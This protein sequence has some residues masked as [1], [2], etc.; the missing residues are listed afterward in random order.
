[1]TTYFAYC[2]LLAFI[3]II[4]GVYFAAKRYP[5]Y[6]HK[7]QFC[8][9]LG[10]SGSP[11]EKFSP[12]IN[13]YPLAVL[14]CFF[15]ISVIQLNTESTLMIVIGALIILHGIGTWVTGYF[16]MDADAY[17][18]VPTL[19]CQIHSLAGMVMLLALLAAPILVLFVPDNTYINATFKTFSLISVIITIFF[20]LVLAKAYK[21][22]GNVGLYQRLG[23]GCQLIWLS[24]LSLM[25]VS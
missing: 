22:K 17:T 7:K 5:R 10:A 19:N 3:W 1:M 16:P 9:E 24:G 20:T 12:C 23:Y 4:L 6:D 13:N 2:G 21:Q 25:M 15:G 14:F 18:K 11:T 8:S